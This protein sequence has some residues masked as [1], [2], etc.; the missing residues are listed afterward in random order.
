MMD[1]LFL[2]CWTGLFPAGVFLVRRRITTRIKV[3][4]MLMLN[5]IFLAGIFYFYPIVL[6]ISVKS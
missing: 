5:F 4:L 3:Y 6:E 1:S 2:L